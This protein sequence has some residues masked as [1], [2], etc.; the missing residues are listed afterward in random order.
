MCDRTGPH[1]GAEICL[2]AIGAQDLHLLSDD[3]N[4]SLFKYNP[5][6]H[7]NFRK[8]HRSH[9]INR[10]EPLTAANPVSYTHLTLPTKRIV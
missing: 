6:R 8:Y 5:K 1:T 4:R 3:P 2:A 7:S 10:S 9:T